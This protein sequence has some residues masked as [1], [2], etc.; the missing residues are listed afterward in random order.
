[1]T[2]SDRW[3]H[4]GGAIVGLGGALT[5]GYLLLTLESGD[6]FWRWPAWIGIGILAIGLIAL[7]LGCLPS[8]DNGASQRQAGGSYSR[9]IQAGRDI[10]IRSEADNE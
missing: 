10:V 5:I 6:T 1:M 7:L 2:H 4:V 8:V 9:N 3:L